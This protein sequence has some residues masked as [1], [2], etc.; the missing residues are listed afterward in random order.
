M[1]P[2]QTESLMYVRRIVPKKPRR[3]LFTFDAK[4]L[5]TIQDER[6]TR[7]AAFEEFAT[8]LN[9]PIEKERKCS[10][11]CVSKRECAESAKTDTHTEATD[12][13][14]NIDLNQTQNKY[15]KD[16]RFYNRNKLRGLAVGSTRPKLQQNPRK[17][18]HLENTNFGVEV[19]P[20]SLSLIHI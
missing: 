19:M 18:R 12:S 17:H 4:T 15:S 1:D 5:E 8:T 3:I 11:R 9:P 16:R 10:Q 2:G 20:L 6:E 14:M 13:A 7:R